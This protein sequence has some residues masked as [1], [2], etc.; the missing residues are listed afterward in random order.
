MNR[1]RISIFSY[2][3]SQYVIHNKLIKQ[4]KTI[5]AYQNVEK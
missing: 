5:T 4:I 3:F 2:V 1:Q